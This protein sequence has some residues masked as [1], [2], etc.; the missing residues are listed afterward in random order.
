MY[1]AVSGLRPS[2]LA[3]F[4]SVPRKNDAIRTRPFISYAVSHRA[5]A[6]PMSYMVYTKSVK[7]RRHPPW[8]FPYFKI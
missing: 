4:L 8:I 7:M 1:V 5:C 3:E 2:A 6:M